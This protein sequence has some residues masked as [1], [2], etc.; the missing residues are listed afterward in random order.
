MVYLPLNPYHVN[1]MEFWKTHR[2][3]TQL[4]FWVWLNREYGAMLSLS[5]RSDRWQFENEQDATFFAMR[6]S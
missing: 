4:G 6:W 2:K 5:E 1:L 3:H